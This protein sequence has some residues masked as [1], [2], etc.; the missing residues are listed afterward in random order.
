MKDTGGD[1]W[2]AELRGRLP[3][4][5]RGRKKAESLGEVEGEP[6]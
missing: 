6:S 5:D 3:T 4:T 1:R 2:R